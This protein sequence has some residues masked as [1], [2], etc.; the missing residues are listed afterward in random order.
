MLYSMLANY[1][2]TF[3]KFSHFMGVVA[4]SAY[5]LLALLFGVIRSS[6]SLLRLLQRVW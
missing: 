4:K 1:S 3:N 5:K 6:K 2:L